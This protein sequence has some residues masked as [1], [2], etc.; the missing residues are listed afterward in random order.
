MLGGFPHIR[1]FV[2][3]MVS[4]IGLVVRPLPTVVIVQHAGK[5]PEALSSVLV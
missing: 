4:S 1:R 3:G 2:H 5:G